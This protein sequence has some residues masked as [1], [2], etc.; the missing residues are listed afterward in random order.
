[1]EKRRKRRT[2]LGSAVCLL[3]FVICLLF[4]V[5]AAAEEKRVF[6]QAGL[7]TEEE[8][9]ELE[10]SAERAGI[11]TD[12]TMVIVTCSD[13]DGKTGQEYADDFYDMG[14]FGTGDDY[15]GALFLIDM[16]NRQLV[17][18][19]SGQM[20]D[21]LTDVRMD[22]ILDEV[23][24]AAADGKYYKAGEIFLDQAADYCMQGREP[25]QY[26]YD[27]DLKQNTESGAYPADLQE[28]AAE[29]LHSRRLSLWEIAAAAAV[30]GIAGLFACIS[31]KNRYE[32]KTDERSI[33]GFNL[34]YRSSTS[35][36]W[37]PGTEQLVNQFVTQ[38]RINTAR[39][40]SGGSSRP[41]RP[42]SRSTVH[43]SSSGRRHGGSSRRF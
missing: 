30:A 39:S 7:F 31:V 43:Q 37:D 15:S 19:T 34:S 20:I 25:D 42:G 12:M 11:E 21:I 33:S 2:S 14:G 17:I 13:A 6:D 40:G 26:F 32:M 27:R 28:G 35:F 16:D 36:S 8:E 9:T 18:S 38:R 22:R 41:G 1:M 10:K 24:E 5:S 4:P 3:V 29:F 23:Y